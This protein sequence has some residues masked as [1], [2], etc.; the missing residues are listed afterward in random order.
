M[1][2]DEPAGRSRGL[3]DPSI[4]GAAVEST[5]REAYVEFWKFRLLSIVKTSG[6]HNV[7]V[8]FEFY[9]VIMKAEATCRYGVHIDL[10]CFLIF[11]L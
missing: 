7:G 2:R 9:F 1:R 5:G 10:F 8:E 11:F 6:K 3:P 4:F